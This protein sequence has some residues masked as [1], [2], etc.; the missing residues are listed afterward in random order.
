MSFD[1]T[2][3]LDS[4]HEWLSLTEQEL[5]NNVSKFYSVN[6]IGLIKNL[7]DLAYRDSERAS[8][9]ETAKRIISHVRDNHHA[10]FFDIEELLQEYSLS[11]EDG[12]TLM[13]LAEALLRIPDSATVDSLIKDKLS[14][15]EWGK[16]FDKDNS[17]FVN[18]STWG[19]MIAGSLVNTNKKSI[20]RFFKN[21]T[22]PVIRTAVD[23]A[24]R[25][26]GQHFVLGRTIKEAMKNAKS[27]IKKGYDYSYD[28]LGESAVTLNEANRYFESYSDAISKIAANSKGSTTRPTLSIKLSALHPR[29]EETHREQVVP[30]LT[31]TIKQLVELGITHN[32][33][34]TIDAE[35][36]DRLE[37]T[38]TLFE[39]V[40]ASPELRGWGKFGIVVQAYSKRALPV[41]CWLTKI[42]KTYGDEVPVRLVKGAYWDSE[43][44]H[45]QVFGLDGYPV[46]TKKEYTDTAYLACARYLLSDVTKGRI[47]PQFASHNAHTVSSVKVMAP[48]GR[49]YEFQ[50]LH[51]MGD[52]LYDSII[53]SDENAKVR[54]Y[55]PVGSHEDL[56]P[57]LVRRL[58]ENGANSSFVHQLSDEST[59]IDNL[60]KRPLELEELALPEIK[61]SIDNPVDIFTNRENSQGINL[62]SKLSRNEF[63]GSIEQYN[64]VKWI[65][66]PMICGQDIQEAKA[67]DVM[68]PYD[69][70][71]RVGVKYEATKKNAEQALEAA[72]ESR[73]DWQAVAVEERANILRKAADL[74]ENNYSELISLCQ[75]EAGKT[76]QDSID[77]IR[78]AVDFCRYYAQQAESHF[79]KPLIL[80]G[81]TGE[82][83]ELHYEGRGVFVCIS[84]WNFPLAIFLGQIAAALVA[85]NTVI[86]KPAETT[87]LI[88]YRATQLLLE[89]G[90]PKQ[91]L[92]LLPGSGSMLGAVLNNDN[93]VSGVVF[94]GSNST[95]RRINL[96][97]A[98]RD[99]NA[100]IAVLI[101]ETGGLNAMLVDSTALPEQ[102]AKD[103]VASAF[104]SAGQ[105]CSALRVLYVQED[106]AD[107]VIDLVK[108][109]MEGL[110]VG[111]PQNLS[112]DVGPVIDSLA[113]GNLSKYINSTRESCKS[114]FQ[115]DLPN[116]CIHGTF[117]P[118]T[119][120]EID[121]ISEMNEEHFGPIL[122]VVRYES[123]DTDKV[124]ADINAK[125]YGLTFGVHS[126][127]TSAYEKIAHNVKV[128]NV[129]IN[130]NQIGA[131][132]G[133]N[134]FGGCGLSGTGPKAGGPNYL[135]RF[136]TEK[137]IT[138][139][140]AAIGGNV[141]L[142]NAV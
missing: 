68:S 129:Y 38:M 17:L 19:L 18:A 87:S 118:P 58:L 70:T 10:A 32:V 112:T 120:I 94:T 82:S 102:V 137:T 110:I 12:V 121:S 72:Y 63:M 30:E 101:A 139:N 44:Q 76:L 79:G 80:P 6:E 75:R 22:K 34:I 90:V 136:A 73:Y 64:N 86:A 123:H 5:L 1:I 133:V 15:K 107:R 124:I 83:N 67:V 95:A 14:G 142:L 52:G 104:S 93:R 31:D 26:M 115:V 125:G 111:N 85:G 56:L 9:R 41:L 60:I 114:V 78:E 100:G 61:S 54:I 27:S 49:A 113:Q 23:R 122:H 106:I 35:E 55:A 11:D 134:P 117:I 8:I 105:R 91:V 24:M 128:G 45:S 7:Y 62:A 39:K 89:A 36:A 127:N 74:L 138:N 13:C 81:P 84:P 47:Y 69:K 103:V 53:T 97:L 37:L 108:G 21:S 2:K 141:D 48:E 50:R 33:G 140:T 16:H 3:L 43:I 46:Y 96:T 126:R 59:P 116:S 66:A 92:H 57:Y 51:G 88:A 40:Y 109:M 28:M 4:S 29:L 20:S 130:R 131:V 25:I 42:S 99:I 77:E 71:Q 65:A 132:V 98:N 119:L 135:L